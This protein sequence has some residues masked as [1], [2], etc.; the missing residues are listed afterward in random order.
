[1]F[2]DKQ[3]EE[4]KLRYKKCL[5]IMGYL[6]RL[7]SDSDKPYIVYRS[8]ENIFCSC[9]HAENLSR[10]DC[11][12]DAKKNNIGIGLKTWVGSNDQKVAEFGKLKNEYKELKGLDLIKKISEYRNERIKFVKRQYETSD[13]YYHILKR[14]EGAMEILECMFEEIDIEHLQLLPSKMKE[15]H[16]NNVYFSDGK[17][18]YHFS[19]SKNTL[20][21]IFD[22]LRL[23]DRFDVE[24]A[25]DPMQILESV[26]TKFH[27]DINTTILKK[28]EKPSICLPLYVLKNGE[29]IV[30]SKSGLN[31]WNAA[32]RKRDPYEI[33]IPFNS[34][35]RKQN[36]DFF[37]D[38][39]KSF[40]L[41]LPNGSKI[42]AKI[43]QQG[44]KAI[45]SNPNK[46]LGEWLLKKVLDLPERTL[47][48][49][50]LLLH[51][52]ID[53]VIFT[54]EDNLTYSIDFGKVGTYESLN[55]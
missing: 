39:D 7:F 33:Y 42:Q 32:G 13:M 17:H 20:Y 21:M 25:Y 24:I 4:D 46:A 35:D 28:S 31:Q 6:S 19:L 38:K 26:F 43:C 16:N 44:G 11:S 2:Y 47:V 41:I 22:K 5:T 48:T 15:E 51:L 36:P 1:M 53:C 8:H 29:K 18:T 34:K 45:M 14:V 10:S 9:F 27:E 23:L 37:P 30:C 50:D 49:Y 52:D 40:T 12:I 54:K 3:E 55:E